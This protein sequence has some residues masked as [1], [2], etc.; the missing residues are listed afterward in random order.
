MISSYTTPDDPFA[1]E[2][3]IPFKFTAEGISPDPVDYFSWMVDI[4]FVHP[5]PSPIPFLFFF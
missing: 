1:F 3:D 5:S 2:V 4:T